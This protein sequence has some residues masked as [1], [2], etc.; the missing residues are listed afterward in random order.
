MREPVQLALQALDPLAHLQAVG[1]LARGALLMSLTACPG[2]ARLGRRRPRWS[3]A[4]LCAIRS[5]QERKGASPRKWCR[6]W[7]ARRD[8]ALADVLGV[9][10][11][12]R[13]GAATRTTTGRWRLTSCSNAPSSPRVVRWTSS[14]SSVSCVGDEGGFAL[15]TR[16]TTRAGSGLHRFPL[17]DR[18]LTT[19]RVPLGR[20]GVRVTHGT[21]APSSEA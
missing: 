14:A 2:S 15:T 3:S 18:P 5:S 6:R 8:A 13:S 16:R 9:F 1:G 20:R 17:E 12:R 4:A 11:S 21:P 7:N 10:E 19:G